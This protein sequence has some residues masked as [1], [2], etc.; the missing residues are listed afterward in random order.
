MTPTD[1]VVMG[2]YNAW[3]TAALNYVAA[4]QPPNIIQKWGTAS[5][6]ET[7]NATFGASGYFSDPT[8]PVQESNE[9]IFWTE[10]I[11]PTAE[12]WPMDPFT[13]EA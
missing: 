9:W 3:R 6:N 11:L 13:Y 12:G 10:E 1:P 5:A 2:I 8:L 7:M 4:T